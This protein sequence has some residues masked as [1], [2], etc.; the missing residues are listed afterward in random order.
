[1]AKAVRR[2]NE[3]LETRNVNGDDYV[4]GKRSISSFFSA[5]CSSSP[6]PSPS[7]C[8]RTKP[9][10]LIEGD[11]D[12][13]QMEKTTIVS[14]NDDDESKVTNEINGDDS[15]ERGIEPMFDMNDDDLKTKNE[16]ISEH[17]QTWRVEKLRFRI[18]SLLFLCL[19]R[20]RFESPS[21]C[22][23]STASTNDGDN[24]T[25]KKKWD[26]HILVNGT[27]KKSSKTTFRFGCR[28]KI[29]SLYIPFLSPCGYQR[30]DSLSSFSNLSLPDKNIT[31]QQ[32][33]DKELES[34]DSNVLYHSHL[35]VSFSH[36]AYTA[37]SSHNESGD[38]IQNQNHSTDL[39]S[40]EMV[41][42]YSLEGNKFTLPSMRTI[43][44]STAA[45]S[46][47]S[48][49]AL[50]TSFSYPTDEHTSIGDLCDFDLSHGDDFD[51]DDCEEDIPFDE[52][53]SDQY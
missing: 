34:S 27:A 22:D 16:K 38:Y 32:I 8:S 11:C 9:L 26:E 7:P 2:M 21:L 44:R 28:T 4:K 33:D 35:G 12:S 10:Y 51:L 29:K 24:D 15:F 46:W 53:L 23:G 5:Y 14:V 37:Q 30:C 17:I 49:S 19:R 40:S 6:I 50:F 25:V 36:P 41:S 48:N 13:E 52:V 20:A 43:I 18:P 31:S 42:K 47:E 3:Q 1:M 39:W 45:K